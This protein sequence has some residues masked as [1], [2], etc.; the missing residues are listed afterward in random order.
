MPRKRDMPC[1]DCGELMWRGKR[2]LPEGQ[3]RCRPCWRKAPAADLRIRRDGKPRGS[4]PQ[5][6]TC[7]RCGED[8]TRPSVRGQVPKWC[9]KCRDM[10]CFER[11][12]AR[13][14]NAFVADV[15]RGRVFEADGYRCHLCGLLTERDK[16][17]PHPKAPTI[18]HVIPLHVGGT[19]EPSNCRTAHFRCNHLKGARGGG[20]QLLLIAI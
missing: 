15:N 12:K 19:H 8:W 11:R 14:K 6:W 7:Q 2:V 20:E 5:T 1:A 4:G 16:K 9:P 13:Q 10:A 18:D 3:A 17:V